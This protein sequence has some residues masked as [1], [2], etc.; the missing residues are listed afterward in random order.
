MIADDE[1]SIIDSLGEHFT[2]WGYTWESAADGEEALAKIMASPPDLLVTDIKMPRI[3]GLELIRRIKD[4][5]LELPV[6]VITAY[7]D[8]ENAI[9]ALRL[10]AVNFFKKPFEFPAI[11]NAIFKLERLKANRIERANVLNYLDKGNMHFV[12]PSNIDLIDGVSNYITERAVEY[13]VI[14][15]NQKFYIQ[16]AIDEAISNAILHGNLHIKELE[17]DADNAGKTREELYRLR[18]S[19]PDYAAKKVYVDAVVNTGRLEVAVTDEGQGFDYSLLP[20]PTDDVNVFDYHGRGIFVIRNIM[21]NV[22]FSHKGNRITL[23]KN[24]KNRN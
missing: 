15:Y 13:G 6:V 4:E 21:D 12:I 1:V 23:I 5:G 18:C 7:F 14:S 8:I 16:L 20:D 17:A 3:D 11:H 24:K 19:Q 22:K 9:T 2:R 10:G